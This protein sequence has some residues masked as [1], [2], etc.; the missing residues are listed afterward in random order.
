MTVWKSQ[1]G[2]I[3][4]GMDKISSFYD[5]SDVQAQHNRSTF[6]APIEG[7]DHKAE[8]LL[9]E[10]NKTEA[11]SIVQNENDLVDVKNI[12]D[13]ENLLNLNYLNI[14]I[15]DETDKQLQKVRTLFATNISKDSAISI[16]DHKLGH[17]MVD[18]NK[19]IIA[20]RTNKR[21]GRIKNQTKE[22]ILA[23]RREKLAQVQQDPSLS[24]IKAI[25][26]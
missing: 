9:D 2:N 22:K 5:S 17:T 3:K 16:S 23:N 19:L 4:Q 24:Q 8:N 25:I 7:K 12:N 13:G 21:K 26:A 15:D 1:V 14:L 10:T 20:S 6:M 18:T 11:T